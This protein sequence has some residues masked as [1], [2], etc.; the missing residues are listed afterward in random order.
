M[1]IGIDI[2]GVITDIERFMIDY[3]VKFCI[4]NNLTYNVKTENYKDKKMLGISAE[5][6]QKFWETYLKDYVVNYKPRD[7]VSEII[8]KLK[9]EG[10]EIYIITARNEEGLVGKDYGHMRDIVKEWFEK[11]DIYYDKIVYTEGSKVPYVIGNYVDIM[12]EDDPKNIKEISKKVPTICFH[13]E[14]NAKV[15]GRN[16]IRAYSWHDVYTKIKQLVK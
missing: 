13:S 16:I 14:Y 6:A 7:F 15:K 11:N 8:K 9:E 4:E 2:D 5:N 12:I 1:R 3:G 10:N